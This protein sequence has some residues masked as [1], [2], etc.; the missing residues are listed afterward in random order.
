M[1]FKYFKLNC[2]LAR[3]IFKMLNGASIT[4]HILLLDV[5][6]IVIRNCFVGRT[7]TCAFPTRQWVRCPRGASDYT[8][9][10]CQ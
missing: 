6:L 5:I 8:N 9:K 7:K 1:V 10:C 4:S 3:S 2:L